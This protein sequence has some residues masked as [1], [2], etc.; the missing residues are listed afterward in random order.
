MRIGLVSDIHA[1]YPAW[2][3]VKQKLDDL[4][5]DQIYCLGDVIGY[6]SHP[7]ECARLVSE[8]NFSQWVFGNHEKGWFKL[9]EALH[10]SDASPKLM[11]AQGLWRELLAEWNMLQHHHPLIQRV[12]SLTEAMLDYVN[13][14]YITNRREAVK[15]WIIHSLELE[16]SEA[17][18]FLF[19]EYKKSQELGSSGQSQFTGD[20]SRS[21]LDRI[22][23]YL[24]NTN[25]GWD[26]WISHGAVGGL[27]RYIYPWTG[28]ADDFSMKD[29]LSK[30]MA[31]QDPPQPLLVLFGHSHVPYYLPLENEDQLETADPF[32]LRYEFPMKLSRWATLINPGSVGY[33]RD[34]CNY[35][36][37]AVLDLDNSNQISNQEWFDKNTVTFW[38]ISYSIDETLQVMNDKLIDNELQLQVKDA[39]VAG[40][41][42]QVPNREELLEIL[43]RQKLEKR[44]VWR[45]RRGC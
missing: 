37:C 28:L 2:V 27:D 4:G 32:P 20:G 14:G 25:L 45:R 8:G 7:L 26:F 11:E 33:S 1:N 40:L 38:R 42:P 34:G 22:N 18:R 15:S 23:G 10:E 5:V 39:E 24:T 12:N 16:G 30:I 6:T 35:A 41:D 3:R 36:C 17:G 21:S 44:R 29:G 13:N 19:D 31:K 43:P 9:W